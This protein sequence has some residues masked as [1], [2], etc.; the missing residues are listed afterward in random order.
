MDMSLKQEDV[1]LFRNGIPC[2]N[3][4]SRVVLNEGIF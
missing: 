2:E 3:C 4:S 1:T